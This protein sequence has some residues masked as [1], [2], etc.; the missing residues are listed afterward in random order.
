MKQIKSVAAI[1]EATSHDL[2]FCS[3]NNSSGLRVISESDAGLV[4]CYNRVDL[5]AKPDQLLVLVDNPRLVFMHVANR[6]HNVR[7]KRKYGISRLSC[8]SDTAKINRTCTV[9]N[10]S[11]IDEGC[12]VGKN[13]IIGD[14]VSLQNCVIGD[15]CIIQSGVSVGEDGFAYER[16]ESL[17][18]ESFPHFGK[19]IIG[20]NV[21]I[22]TN[23]SVA[24]GS[25]KDTVIQDGTKIDALTHVAHNVSIGNNCSI[26]AGTVIGGSTTIGDTCWLGLNSTV[27]HKLKIGNKVI[28]ARESS[29]IDN[30]PDEDIVAGVPARSIKHKVNSNQLFLMA[31][32]IKPLLSN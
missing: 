8:I 15:N 28:M 9:G 16:N 19:V 4:L 25:L 1:D 18:L 32:Q 26:T 14:R 20:N 30:I 7:V 27:K 10:F 23:C 29:V 31:G 11:V 5:S 2:T 24:R 22:S 3:Q 13:T 12:V 21:E 6:L 17:E